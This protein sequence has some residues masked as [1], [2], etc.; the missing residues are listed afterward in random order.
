MSWIKVRTNLHEDP[1]VFYIA[2]QL[3]VPVH[4][5]VGMLVRL[6]CYADSHT[7]DG[8]LRMVSVDAVNT[9]VGHEHF[10]TVLAR[11]DW[12]KPTKEG[13]MLPRYEQHNGSTAKQRAQGARAVARHRNRVAADGNGESVTPPVTRGEEKRA[14]KKNAR[15]GGQWL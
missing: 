7:T 2:S 10:A 8:V 11:I 13:V 14:E 15:K 12:L 1:R 4:H 5:A 3:N 6:W 9:L